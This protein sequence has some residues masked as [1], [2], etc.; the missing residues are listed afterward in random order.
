MEIQTA[1]AASS[2]DK[3]PVKSRTIL[4]REASRRN[5]R[6]SKGPKTAEGKARSCRNARRHGLS[7]SAISDL[8]F[9]EQTMKL[10]HAIAGANPDPTELAIATGIAAAFFDARRVRYAECALMSRIGMRE[11][12]NHPTTLARFETMKRYEWR[13]AARRNKLIWQ[14]VEWRHAAWRRAQSG[15]TNPTLAGKLVAAL[16]PNEPGPAATPASEQTIGPLAERTQA[17]AAGGTKSGNARL[18]ETNLT[19]PRTPN[20]P[21]RVRPAA[22]ASDGNN[23]RDHRNFRTGNTAERARGS[24][25]FT[26]R[27][28]TN[29]T[30]QNR[31]LVKASRQSPRCRRARGPPDKRTRNAPVRQRNVVRAGEI[32]S[33]RIRCDRTN[34]RWRRRNWLGRVAQGCSFGAA[35]FAAAFSS[36]VFVIPMR[37]LTS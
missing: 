21:H 33:A 30:A 23:N 2:E 26:A 11:F 12:S 20:E 22:P 10:A 31:A 7:V 28:K 14:L 6:K 17:A 8:A 5:G 36:R 15:E 3:S 32:R 37:A 25:R 27:D 4:Q 1:S 13:F 16:A 34:P 19:A 9:H 35:V 29:P 18:G 24:S